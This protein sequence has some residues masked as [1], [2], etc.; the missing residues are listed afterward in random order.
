MSSL[1]VSSV[2]DSGSKWRSKCSIQ[3]NRLRMDCREDV[4]SHQ[5]SLITPEILSLPAR[6]VLRYGKVKD[7]LS[8]R[9]NIVGALKNWKDVADSLDYPAEQILGLFA[10]DARPGLVLLEDWMYEKHGR[11]GRLVDVLMDLQLYSCLEVIYECVEGTS[12]VFVAPAK[13]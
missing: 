8:L 10:H 1:R 12:S 4:E 9:L 2:T 13:F 3:L 11:L 7:S 6:E 5:Q